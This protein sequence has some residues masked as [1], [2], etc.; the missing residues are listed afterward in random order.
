MDRH[1]VLPSIFF[2]STTEAQDDAG[3]A[4]LGSPALGRYP[5][6]AMARRAITPTRWARYSALA[7]MSALRP[8]CGIC[9]AHAALRRE[10]FLD[11]L[12]RLVCDGSS[13]SLILAGA[14]GVL[15]RASRVTP[16]P[17]AHER[18]G[19]SHSITSSASA[20]SRGDIVRP[21]AL[22]VLR[23]T[24]KNSLVGNS[25]GRSLGAVPFKILCTYVALRRLHQR[26]STP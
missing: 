20:T 13:R 16:S 1:R 7:W 17:L 12:G 4:A 2:P 9:K 11:L 6:P 3:R 26:V 14:A 22:A 5:Q 18:F 19:S 10:P 8:S 15:S 24:T 21:N 25:T 23:L